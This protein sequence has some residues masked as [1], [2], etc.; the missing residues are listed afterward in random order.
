MILEITKL[1]MFIFREKELKEM[2]K[3]DWNILDIDEMDLKYRAI[4]IM[5]EDRR[6]IG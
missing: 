4:Y 1:K 6:I 3:L 2:Q 5:F